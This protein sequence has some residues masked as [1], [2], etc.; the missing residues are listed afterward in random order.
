MAESQK[1]VSAENQGKLQQQQQQQNQ[2]KDVGVH[3]ILIP[4]SYPWVFYFGTRAF[5][6]VVA[7]PIFIPVLFAFPFL[8]KFLISRNQNY[9]DFNGTSII[10]T[11]HYFINFFL[12]FPQD[13]VPKVDSDSGVQSSVQR[14]LAAH[15]P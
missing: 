9:P 7:I 1:P 15:S 14:H 11:L 13:P 5:W 8:N 10:G 3:G 6:P 2:M 12:S 4:T